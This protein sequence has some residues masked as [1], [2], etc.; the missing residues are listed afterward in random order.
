LGIEG[1]EGR[2]ML[3]AM[4]L[5]FSTLALP[6]TPLNLQS[7]QF[8]T[9]SGQVTFHIAADGGFI[10]LDG[11]QV[12]AM[13]GGLTSGVVR[14]NTSNVINLD[15]VVIVNGN[16]TAELFTDFNPLGGGFNVPPAVIA[17]TEPQLP[18]FSDTPAIVADDVGRPQRGTSKRSTPV[19]AA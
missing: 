2:W 4:S 9:A 19:S 8:A 10:S 5:E 14:S 17:P 12:Q 16:S 7:A 1:M 18:S 6:V 13:G 11:L 3:S 15:T